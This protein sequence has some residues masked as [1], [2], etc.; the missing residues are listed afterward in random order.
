MHPIDLPLMTTSKKTGKTATATSPTT[1][2]AKRKIDVLGAEEA[3]FSRTSDSTGIQSLD[4]VLSVFASF[5]CDL[6]CTARQFDIFDSDD[7]AIWDSE[8][9]IKSIYVFA[10]S[11]LASAALIALRDRGLRS[12][13]PEHVAPYPGN[14]VEF[15]LWYT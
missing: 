3:D 5:Y 11:E 8:F 4:A 14:A 6:G 10:S 15:T 12:V 1:S 13:L 9:P 7:L 2:S